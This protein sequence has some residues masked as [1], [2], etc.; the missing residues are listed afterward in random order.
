MEDM[1]LGSYNRAICTLHRVYHVYGLKRALFP[2]W[3]FFLEPNSTTFE[4]PKTP[5]MGI[6]GSRYMDTLGS[7]ILDLEHIFSPYVVYTC[8]LQRRASREHPI[9]L[10]IWDDQ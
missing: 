5:K 2:G 1:A 6:L 8:M 10:P 7:W 3:A 4:T 9:I